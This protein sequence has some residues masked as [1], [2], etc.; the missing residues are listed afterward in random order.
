MAG[1]MLKWSGPCSTIMEKRGGGSAPSLRLWGG[2]RV[3]FVTVSSAVHHGS[4][5]GGGGGGRGRRGRRGVPAGVK[6][7]AAGR[8]PPYTIARYVL[9]GIIP[10]GVT[11]APPL[12]IKP[13]K[14]RL[15]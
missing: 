1:L 15:L 3:G 5:G 12:P 13:S 11:V 10:V 4:G 14:R 2:S 9:H 7:S 8:H 6:L